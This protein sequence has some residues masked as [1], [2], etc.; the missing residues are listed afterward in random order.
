[1][2]YASLTLYALGLL[3]V[4]SHSFVELNKINKATG[5]NAS[6]LHYLKMEKFSLLISLIVVGVCLI[7]KQ[8]VKQLEYV[9]D[10]LGLA[11]VAIGYMGQSLL[12]WGMGKATKQIGIETE[13]SN[14][15]IP[16]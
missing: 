6:I 9:S 3:G 14:N 12:I 16:K 5:G 7:A 13:E 4:L 11:F 2:D 15:N 10:W 1:M 8:E